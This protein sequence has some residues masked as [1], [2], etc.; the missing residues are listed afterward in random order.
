MIFAEKNGPTPEEAAKNAI[1]AH[2]MMCHFESAVR[3]TK[4][5]RGTQSP[6]ELMALAYLD[7]LSPT[8]T[9]FYSS[10]FFMAL[11]LSISSV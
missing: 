10:L 9:I 2:V 7:R 3:K 4:R 5:R 6:K 8:G 1:E 11:S